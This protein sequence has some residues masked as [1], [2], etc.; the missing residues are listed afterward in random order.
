MESG[1][2]QNLEGFLIKGNLSL[3]P[4]A[5]PSWQGDGSIEG[6]GT[7]YFDLIREYNY[8]NGVNIQD[9]TFRNGQLNIPYTLPSDNATSASVIIDG[10]ISVKHTQNAASITS[11]GALTVVGGVSIGKN[12]IV[13]GDV[14]ISGNFIKNVAYPVLGTD[15]V[16]KD[17]VDD[18]ASKLSGN[19][20]TG[21]VIIAETD[22]DAIRGFDFFTT[23]TTKLDLKIPF[24]I[25]STS[26]T[27]LVVSGGSTL[28]GGTIISGG[29]LNLSDN[30]ITNVGVPI[31]S[32]DAATKQYVD[33][34][35]I[36]GN[37]TTGQLIVADSVGDAIR[38]FDNLTY[39]GITITLGSTQNITGSVGG[40]FVCYGGISISKDVFIGGILNVNNNVIQNVGYPIDQTDAATKQYVDDHKLQGN[41]TTG[42]VIIGETDGDA[43]RGYSSFTFDGSLLTLGTSS[44]LLLSNTE[45]SYN[46]TSGGVF[47]S[48]GGVVLKKNVIIGGN[49][50]VNGNTIK[51][52]ATPVDGLDATNK[53]YVDLVST[54][55]AGNFTTGQVIIADSNGDAIRGYDNI[56]F[57]GDGTLGNLVLNPYTSL[58]LTNTSDSTGLGSGGSIVSYGGASFEKSVY[59]GGQLD[60]N[61][62]RITNVSTPL[63]DF[64][65]VNKAYVD[66][67]VSS[68]SDECCA[69][70]GVSDNT[71]ENTFILNN[72]VTLAED[73]SKFNFDSTIKAFIS[74][75]YIQVGDEKNAFY[76][77]RGINSGNEWKITSTFIG[78][79][80]GVVFYIRTD[81]GQGIVQYTNSN[82][83]GVT[84]IKFRTITQINDV[85]SANQINLTLANNVLSYQTITGLSY[86][87][88][89]YNA[90]KIIVYVSNDVDDKYCLYF[91]SCLLK[92]N[93]WIMQ[94]YFIGDNTGVTFNIE[95][96][97]SIGKIQ[98]MNPNAV[99][100]YTIR[101]QQF[102][103]PTSSSSITLTA[104]TLVPNA[105]SDKLIF[106]N[107][108]NTFQL[109]VYVEI[110]ELSKY[111][112]YE[113]EGY[114]QTDLWKI[115]TRYI[116]DRTGIIFDISTSGGDGYLKYTNPNAYD[117]KIR[118]LKNTPLIFQPLQVSKGGTGNTQLTP[119]A[120]LR[121]NGTDPIV[122]TDD[123]IYKDFQLILG[124]DSEII[125]SNTSAAINLTTGGSIT[126]YGG[127]SIGKN[128]LVGKEIQIY[129]TSAALNLTT[130]GTITTYGGVSIGKNLLVGDSLIVKNIDITPNTGD[131]WAERSFNA[132]NNQQL[133]DDVVNFTF[134][135]VSI[136]SFSGIACITVITD[137]IEYD[138]LYELKGIKK[139]SGWILNTSYIGDNTNIKFSITPFGQVQYTSPNLTDWISTTM[140][141]RAMT[142]TF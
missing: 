75:V 89:A 78:Q 57:A 108:T 124:N 115:N 65:A 80:T 20:T 4:S 100:T 91:L 137:S 69:G 12:L 19:F 35:K 120:V 131:I 102:K 11:G 55:L 67:L 85:A 31:D 62:Q 46:L 77:I 16:N 121:G 71:Y 130:G 109:T 117:A 1:F 125:L 97:N 37:F 94:S 30:R 38:G 14:D 74:Y 47:V 10:G 68:M 17:Y 99:G 110:V 103:I 133:P 61:V 72:N 73:I 114:L 6:S 90:V 129:D 123:F 41:F 60:L 139:S 40:S 33:D 66:A 42:Q 28:I 141:F 119:Y 51:N 25:T 44:S 63:E 59:I 140:K 64:D 7:L 76:T 43:I 112:L 107:A 101:Y 34:R 2:G 128:L 92:G 83:T 50:D 82:Y 56:A 138:T 86:I 18:V 5:N 111:A 22:G 58:Y 136:K 45:N 135:E 54:R 21:Q 53:D 70:G 93:E 79:G 52:L 27:S 116:G 48:E 122:G 113:I 26:G 132:S 118:Y 32:S 134:N 29:A 8:S 81:A 88:S 9:V 49:V 105:V 126:T 95:T 24:N 142:T 23:D 39:D 127:V 106:S 3:A 15:G 98:Y 96:S 104:N 87:N 84:T 13:G 36:N